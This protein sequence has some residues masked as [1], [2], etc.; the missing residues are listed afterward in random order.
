MSVCALPQLWNKVNTNSELFPHKEW[1]K[2]CLK[3]LKANS[4]IV[5]KPLD[6]R[7]PTGRFGYSL[8]ERPKIVSDDGTAFLKT[9]G[10]IQGIAS[11]A[12]EEAART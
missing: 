5:A 4:R 9:P 11:M 8:G 6:P 10:Q 7:N 3:F 12:G 1:M 2:R